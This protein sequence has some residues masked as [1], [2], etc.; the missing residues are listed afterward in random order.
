[1]PLIKISV[2]SGVREKPHLYLRLALRI[3][4]CSLA[5]GGTAAVPGEAQSGRRQRKRLVGGTGDRERTHRRPRQK[6]R[7]ARNCHS[8]GRSSLVRGSGL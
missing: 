4:V 6:R 8:A 5:G 2:N 7:G 1:M 3:Q